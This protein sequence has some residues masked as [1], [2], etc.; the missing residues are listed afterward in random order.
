MGPGN[1]SGG[2]TGG[3]KGAGY[4]DAHSE[5]QRRVIETGDPLLRELAGRLEPQGPEAE[6]TVA[7]YGAGTGATSVHA[8][9]IVLDA[10]RE[11]A[12]EARFTVIHND[13]IGN[14]FDS[15]FETVAGE[16][17]YL[18]PD[19]DIVP[20]ASAGSFFTRVA[21]GGSVD[22]GMCSNAAHWFREQPR[23]ETAGSIYFAD[24]PAAAREALTA[25]A[26]A[27]WLAFLEARAAELRPGGHLLVQGIATADDNRVS[28][29]RL[30]R[31]M[32]LV[33]EELVESGL[34]RAEVLNRYV[35]PVYCRTA[36]ETGAP[37]ADGGPLHGVLDV[38]HLDTV[39]VADPYWEELE[40][41]GDRDAYAESYTAFVRAFAEPTL[42]T[43]LFEPGAEGS[44]P[45]ALAD[46]FFRRFRHRTAADPEA[47]RYEAWITRVV[48]RRS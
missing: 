29:A 37:V 21:P 12:P 10:V 9:G 39:Q 30:L 28:A 48:L 46:E 45:A 17:G 44:S 11:R 43:H 6:L 33:A 25:F 23:L 27:D 20:M 4:Y 15:L 5:Y 14:A 8:V 2:V 26:A 38:V 42:A 34:L 22:L 40:R 13:V 18:G 36:G 31:V 47:G 41:D 7:D 19:L 1:E 35:F 3:M 24:A 16:G 32:G